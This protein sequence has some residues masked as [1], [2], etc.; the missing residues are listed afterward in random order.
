MQIPEIGRMSV[1]RNIQEK[2]QEVEE[3]IIIINRTTEKPRTNLNQ[4]VFESTERKVGPATRNLNEGIHLPQ[5]KIIGQERSRAITETI[6]RRRQIRDTRNQMTKSI[7]KNRRK[8]GKNVI[9][10]NTIYLLLKF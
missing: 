1:T 8:A 7:R 6:V 10:L 2:D 3:K 9:D 4:Q 5:K